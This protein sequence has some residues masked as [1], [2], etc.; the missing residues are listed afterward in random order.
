[1]KIS[2]IVFIASILFLASCS[3][4]EANEHGHEHTGEEHEHHEEIKQEEFTISGDSIQ[5]EAPAHNNPHNDENE[6]D[7]H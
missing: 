6:H 5:I 4:N 1:M 7:S 2:N 3:S